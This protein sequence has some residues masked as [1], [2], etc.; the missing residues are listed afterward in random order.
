MLLLS[1]ACKNGKRE[2]RGMRVQQEG[3]S[4]KSPDSVRSRKVVT[5]DEGAPVAVRSQLVAVTL[6]GG[7]ATDVSEKRPL[8]G[9]GGRRTG[10]ASTGVSGCQGNE[11][12][13]ERRRRVSVKLCWFFVFSGGVVL[14]IQ[15]KG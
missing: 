3:E 12:E 7:R 13:R 6:W 5:P 15:D 11:R 8:Y 10:S 1:Q 14:R 4:A 9:C 2:Q